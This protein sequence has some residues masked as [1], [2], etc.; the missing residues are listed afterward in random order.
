MAVLKIIFRLLPILVLLPYLNSAV[1]SSEQQ[2]VELN[3][4]WSHSCPH[5]LE[6]KP[7]IESLPQKYTWLQL[8]SYDLIDSPDNITRYT[9]M[10]EKLGRTA[11]SVPGFI[12]CEQIIIGFQ[13]IE[14]T[15]KSIEKQLLA[16]HKNTLVVSEKPEPFVVP[17]LGEVNY[18][19]FSLPAFTLII[20]ALD[21]FN[22]CAFFVLFFLLSLIVHTRSRVR[23]AIIGGVFVIFSGLMYF[24][25]MAAWLNVFLLTKQLSYITAIAGLIA[26]I[27]G[28]INFKDYFFFKQGISL[29]IPES[30]KPTL[31]KRMRAI[32]QQGKW[33]AMIAATVV[34]A[35]AANS[36]ELLCTAGLPM[37]YTRVL[38]LNALS[39]SEYYAYLALYNLVYIVPLLIIVGFFTY[40]LGSKK[41]SEQEGRLLKLMSGCMMLGLGGIL[42]FAPDLLGNML[43]SMSVL[44]GAVLITIVIALFERYR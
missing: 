33:P 36:Y 29:S 43:V 9:E 35:I 23:I 4:F 25:F 5:C 7:F 28:L 26:L 16:C 37:V 44:L 27:V 42:L 14:T 38:T 20:A 19:D 34:L 15:G 41:I 1:A 12:F 17:V 31:F 10:A 11:N 32:T 3:F 39:S 40:T 18:Q 30:A 22:P 24:L 21:A 8:N 13:S 6:A 2:A